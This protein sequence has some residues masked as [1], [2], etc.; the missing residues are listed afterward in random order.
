MVG[1]GLANKD[2]AQR[3][4]VSE[5]A[6]KEQVSALLRRLAVPNRA[7]LADAA[8]MLRVVG[9]TEVSPEWLELLFLHAPIMVALLEG[10]DH[11][12]VAANDAYRAAAG[13]DVAGRTLR[14][15]IPDLDEAGV[16]KLLDESFRTGERRFAAQVRA[17]W[18][19]SG[20][21]ERESG[22]ITAFVEPMRHEDGR[23]GGVAFFGVDVTAEVE[24]RMKARELV[25]EREAVLDQ[26]PSGV[27]SVDLDGTITHLNAF[28]RRLLGLRA[29]IVGT[30]AWDT[31]SLFDAW[32]GEDVSLEQRPLRRALRGEALPATRYA[33]VVAANDARITIGVSATPLF[34]PSGR[35]RGAVAVFT[36]SGAPT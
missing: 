17:R 15:V 36:P 6:V 9:S 23:V 10:P 33:A 26:L 25:E 24:A 5:Q 22:Y 20:A 28:G 8:A 7:G 16:A 2:I 4:G 13:R 14:E 31:I 32:S 12:F 35:V 34:D 30:S 19:R 21:A 3:L 29:D 18:H 27:I 1:E 11:R